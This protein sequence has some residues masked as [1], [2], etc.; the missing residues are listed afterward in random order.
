M[1][2]AS[3]FKFLVDG[4][5]VIPGVVTANIKSLKT[6]LSAE[7]YPALVGVG[8]ICGPKIASYM[9][10]GGLL[11]WFVFIPAIQIVACTS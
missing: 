2:L 6:E 9:L 4:L 3:I 5:K 1:G 7:V 11:G 8:Y 10:A